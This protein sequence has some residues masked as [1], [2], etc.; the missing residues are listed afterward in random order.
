[1]QPGRGSGVPASVTQYAPLASSGRQPSTSIIAAAFSGF[2]SGS[3]I[4]RVSSVLLGNLTQATNSGHW[5]WIEMR[6]WAKRTVLYNPIQFHPIRI[7]RVGEPPRNDVFEMEIE[8]PPPPPLQSQAR[9]PRCQPAA[10]ALHPE[11]LL[12]QPP[13]RGHLSHSSQSRL[14]PAPQAGRGLKKTILPS[15][16]PHPH[17]QGNN[18]PDLPIWRRHLAA[19]RTALA[20]QLGDRDSGVMIRAKFPQERRTASPASRSARQVGELARNTCNEGTMRRR[21]GKIFTLL[22]GQ[23]KCQALFFYSLA[24]F[25]VNRTDAM[26][27]DDR[28][29]KT[30]ASRDDEVCAGTP[31]CMHRAG[32]PGLQVSFHRTRKKGVRERKGAY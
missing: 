5:K 1:L 6:D 32:Q 7:N 29:S 3:R 23:A 17:A 26:E 22:H 4:P 19:A 21:S 10:Q 28:T 30:G 25:F 2:T 16:V 13:R 11:K 24:P 9:H 27:K 14:P 8:L 18:L 15:S 12:F 31:P 20:R